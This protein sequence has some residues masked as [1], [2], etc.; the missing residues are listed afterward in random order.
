MSNETSICPVGTIFADDYAG[1]WEVVKSTA[2]TVTVRPVKRR[3]VE[4]IDRWETSYEPVR[5]Y[6]ESIWHRGKETITRKV[7]N[8]CR[9]KRPE[10]NMIKV[11]SSVWAW[12]WDGKP[13]VH[14]TYN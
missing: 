13:A 8:N 5:E 2:K 10:G 11:T 12:Q 1:F 3:R 9:D 7:S 6:E 4:I 14:D